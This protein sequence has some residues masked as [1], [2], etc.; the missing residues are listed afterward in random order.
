[1]PWGNGAK[2]KPKPQLA[3]SSRAHIAERR[4]EAELEHHAYH[5]SEAAASRWI[6]TVV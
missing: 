2:A 5:Q 6:E 3:P 1:M 4:V